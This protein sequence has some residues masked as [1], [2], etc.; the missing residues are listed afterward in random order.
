M[1]TKDEYYQ[2]ILASQ[3]SEITS[4]KTALAELGK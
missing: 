4:L 2:K 1:A 3:Q